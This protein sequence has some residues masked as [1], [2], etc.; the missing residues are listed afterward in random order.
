M[1]MR[2]FACGVI[3]AA[4]LSACATFHDPGQL[5]CHATGTYP[6][7]IYAK[8]LPELTYLAVDKLTLCGWPNISPAVP[9]VVSSI[10]DSRLVDRSTTFGNVVADLVRSRLA[11]DGMNVSDAR[12]R[13]GMLLK[14]DQGEMMLVRDPSS[15]VPPPNK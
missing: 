13:S 9:M 10:T 2:S 5:S 7:R 8:S 11:Q 3:G 6:A 4:T 14:P 12:L 1:R 15:L